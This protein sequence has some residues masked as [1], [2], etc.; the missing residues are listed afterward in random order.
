MN[1]DHC[2]NNTDMGEPK[3]VEEHLSFH[4]EQPVP[5]HLCYGTIFV[6]VLC[7]KYDMRH[8]N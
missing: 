8:S 1:M 6:F 4:S 3:Y 5:Y 2:W 7:E